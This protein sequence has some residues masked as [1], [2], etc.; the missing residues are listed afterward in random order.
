[1]LNVT[2]DGPIAMLTLARPERF[3]AITI[4][5]MEALIEQATNLSNDDSVR[6][7]ILAAE[8]KHFSVGAD[9]KAGAPEG[10]RSEKPSLLA[11]RRQTELGQRLLRALRE[12]RQPTICAIQGVATGGGACIAMACDFRIADHSARLGFGEVK[13]GMNLMWQAVPLCTALIGPARAKRMIMTGALFPADEV[14]PWGLLDEVVAPEDLAK[15]VRGWAEEYAA[16]PPVAVQMIKRSV[17]AVTGALDAA[18]MHM[19]ADQFLLATGSEDSKEG[20][21][22]FLEKRPPVFTG[23]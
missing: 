4:E 15:T 23:N 18:I 5:L 19:D 13:L 20:R 14:A 2:I 22:A 12:I 11:R 6:A 7:V 9:Q 10:S 16:L 17:N 21:R 3:N 8:G 1:M